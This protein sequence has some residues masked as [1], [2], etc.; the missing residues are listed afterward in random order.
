MD[1]LIPIQPF[2]EPDRDFGI[3]WMSAFRPNCTFYPGDIKS[4]P[5][6]RYEIQ[7]IASLTLNGV[8][9][10]KHIL[11]PFALFGILNPSEDFSD[12]KAYDTMSAADREQ[13]LRNDADQ[14][15]RWCL[16]L[17]GVLMLIGVT[18]FLIISGL[19]DLRA[20]AENDPKHWFQRAGALVVFSGIFVEWR[21]VEIIK[22]A[23]NSVGRVYAFTGRTW[24]FFNY[25]RRISL[26]CSLVGTVIWAYGDL[27]F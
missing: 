6:S 4:Y 15:R 24:P 3:V 13:N 23:P 22:D 12:R 26:I 7:P 8:A 21:I 20:E 14:V 25:M 2:L 11:L 19:W 1:Q 16:L 10:F 27:F 18:M 5:R 17:F 9:L